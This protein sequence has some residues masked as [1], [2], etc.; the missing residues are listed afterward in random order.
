M[1]RVSA[2]AADC[3]RPMTAGDACFDGLD[4]PADHFARRALSADLSEFT[5][6][7]G[8]HHAL[9]YDLEASEDGPAQGMAVLT[10]A[11]RPGEAAYLADVLALSPDMVLLLHEARHL[12]E[13]FGGGHSRCREFLARAADLLDDL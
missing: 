12:V 3:P 7:N 13:R 2:L 1:P 8:A 4:I 11:D 10:Y 5:D 9:V 6:D